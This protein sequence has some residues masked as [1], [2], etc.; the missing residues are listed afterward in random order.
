MNAHATAGCLLTLGRDEVLLAD[1]RHRAGTD[2]YVAILLGQVAST[3]QILH[4]MADTADVLAVVLPSKARIASQDQI[5][6]LVDDVSGNLKR[7][8]IDARVRIVAVVWNREAIVVNVDHRLNVET[9]AKIHACDLCK[10]WAEDFSG[11]QLEIE[12]PLKRPGR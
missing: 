4:C 7:R 3:H 8:W 6:V 12:R 11:H 1:I 2:E 10:S 5:A 9:Q